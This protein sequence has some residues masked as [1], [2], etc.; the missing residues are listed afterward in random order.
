[1]FPQSQV[2]GKGGTETK[3]QTAPDPVVLEGQVAAKLVRSVEMWRKVSLD[4]LLKSLQFS[5]VFLYCVETQP[6]KTT[7]FKS[8][9]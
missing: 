2:S 7:D 5:V 1:M 9:G 3:G 4:K 8:Q 6:G